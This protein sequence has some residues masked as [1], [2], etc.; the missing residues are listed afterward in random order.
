[1]IMGKASAWF[2]HLRMRRGI[3]I[4]SQAFFMWKLHQTSFEDL[5]N[6]IFDTLNKPV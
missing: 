1:M 5:I 2:K 6:N 4:V 3:S